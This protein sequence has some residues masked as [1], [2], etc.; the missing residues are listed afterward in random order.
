[1]STRTAHPSTRPATAPAPTSPTVP[2]QAPTSASASTSI[3]SRALIVSGLFGIAA[4][5]LADLPGKMQ[6]VPYLGWA[7]VGLI[8]AA[9]VLAE[10]VA[11]RDDR[12]LLPASAGLSAAVLVGFVINRTIG[13]PN[14]MDDIGNWT[15]PL[16]M[17]S[18][19]VEAA[20]I[21]IAARA[22]FARD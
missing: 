18:L 2:A 11:T 19:L 15:E 5:H 7:Y 14:A 16:G 8:G 21:W 20:V 10:L 13:M 3:I 4:I 6:E 17:I 9:L 12:R 22:W 1:M